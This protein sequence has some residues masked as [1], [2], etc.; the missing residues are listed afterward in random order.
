VYKPLDRAVVYD[1]PGWKR[2]VSRP[3]PTGRCCTRRNSLT[4]QVHQVEISSEYPVRPP[5]FRLRLNSSPKPPM[6][7][8]DGPTA[9]GPPARAHKLSGAEAAAAYVAND[10]R[11]MERE[12]NVECVHKLGAPAHN[13][14]LSFQ[15]LLSDTTHPKTGLHATCCCGPNSTRP[16][17]AV[18]S[19]THLRRIHL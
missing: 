19:P 2:Q 16:P 11:A 4:A 14:V 3:R 5:S 12:L 1:V 15:V 7:P 18:A 13:G 17:E 9:S 6:L 8:A 10:L